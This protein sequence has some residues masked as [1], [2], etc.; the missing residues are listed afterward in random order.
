MA[1]RIPLTQLASRLR[2]ELQEMTPSYRTLYFWH[3]DGVLPLKQEPGRRG[4]YADE[5][6][7]PAIIEAVR[8]AQGRRLTTAA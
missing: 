7:L 5:D 1:A 4:Y 8:A 3:L 2:P 6:D